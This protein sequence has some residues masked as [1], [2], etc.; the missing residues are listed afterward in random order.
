[1][2]RYTESHRI[3]CGD[4]NSRTGRA[5]DYDNNMNERFNE[6]G[7]INKYGRSLLNLCINTELKIA[8]GRIFD[9]KGIGRYTYYSPMGASTIAYELLREDNMISKF[10]VLPKLVESDH[11]PIKFHILNSKI[12]EL[13]SAEMNI[14]VNDSSPCSNVYDEKIS[15]T[16][17]L[18]EMSGHVLRLTKMLCAVAEGCNSDNLCDIFIGLLENAISPLFP[19]KQHISNSENNI[20]NNFPSNPWYDKECKSLK[21]V[22]NTVAKHKKFNTRLGE[23]NIL[24]GQY[25]QLIQK[26][27]IHYQ[28]VKLSQLENMR[29]EDPNA[30]WKFWKSLKPRNATKGP[31]MSQFVK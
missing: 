21:H 10:K 30:Y 15:N 24:L 7:V 25:K 16:K 26:K 23:Y 5:P 28:Q 11:C 29:T 2:A 8:N 13:S 6:D 9:D 20:K 27:K 4:F 3:R 22:L 12:K 19:K 18:Y 17:H 31:T 14:H 1:M